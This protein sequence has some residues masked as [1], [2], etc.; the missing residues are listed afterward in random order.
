M[1]FGVFFIFNYCR[2][3]CI[4]RQKNVPQKGHAKVNINYRNKKK[5]HTF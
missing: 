1:Q 4:Y 2:L 5:L 3:I